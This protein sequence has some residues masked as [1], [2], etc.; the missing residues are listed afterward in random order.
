MSSYILS[1]EHISKRYGKNLV[2]RDV[3]I[4]LKQGEI[5]GL[6]GK[7]GSGKRPYFVFFRASFPDMEAR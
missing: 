5:Y 4:H 7:N 3:S 6:I 1:G 2:L